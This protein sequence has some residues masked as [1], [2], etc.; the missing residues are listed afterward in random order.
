AGAGSRI[1]LLF[2]HVVMPGP[3]S[4]TELAHKAVAL[5]PQLKVLFTSGYTR[6]ALIVDG[7][8]GEG[9]QLLSKPYQQAQLAQ[10]IREL[11]GKR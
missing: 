8:L 9:V 5:L 1:D 11:L 2:T 6:N 3:V 10:R 4:S 7:R